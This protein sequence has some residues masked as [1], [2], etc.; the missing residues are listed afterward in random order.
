MWTLLL[1]LVSTAL[2]ADLTVVF[3]SCAHQRKPQP[4]WHAI[5]R[6]AADAIVLLGDN[7]YVD[8]EDPDAFAPA[9]RRLARKPA[10]RRLRRT[11][12]LFMTWDDHDYG[13]ND[14]G[15]DW[16]LKTQARS[17]LMSF[18]DAPD[19]DP[20]RSQEG[21]IYASWTR[22]VGDRTVQIVLLDTRWDRT[23]LAT[24]DPDPSRQ[25]Q[26][27]YVPLDAPEARM[28]GEA[29]WAWLTSVLD[30][31]ADV[32]LIGSS[33]PVLPFF[34]GW[35]TWA[36]LPR[37]QARLLDLL[38]RA[39]GAVILSGDTHWAELSR[40]DAGL[41]YPLWELT[42]S[43]LTQVWRD[44]PDN[45]FRVEDRIYAG[46]NYGRVILDDDRLS[47][48]IHDRRGRTIWTHT[49]TLETLAQP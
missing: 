24:G 16:P 4:I 21:G 35:E 5:E 46:A 39:G 44:I 34:T 28:L 7:V 17:A 33:I 42:S 47:L 8:S 3:G 38:G 11:T 41:P 48:S 15:A 18:L 13:W 36:N 20:R 6:E 9:Y 49:L 25:G 43:G 32:R 30:E 14:V 2:C 40:R 26:G 1:L 45:L 12:P 23:A 37:E 22:A 27:P 31:P 19:D 29:Q 10:L